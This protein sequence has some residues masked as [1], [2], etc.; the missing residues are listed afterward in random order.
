MNIDD[1]YS[2]TRLTYQSY[3][4]VSG[5]YLPIRVF[6]VNFIKESPNNTHRHSMATAAH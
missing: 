1:Y 3:T 4:D 2:S 5:Y 6:I